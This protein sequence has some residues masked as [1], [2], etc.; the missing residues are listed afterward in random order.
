VIED[1]TK[2]HSREIGRSEFGGNLRVSEEGVENPVELKKVGMPRAPK[3]HSKG[4]HLK[5]MDTATETH[6]VVEQRII[7]VLGLRVPVMA[8]SIKG[9]ELH[10]HLIVRCPHRVGADG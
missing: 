3:P 2:G 4:C 1:R 9:E 8:S 5:P 7:F 10:T 6:A